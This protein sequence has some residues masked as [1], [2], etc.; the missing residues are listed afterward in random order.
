MLRQAPAKLPASM[1]HPRRL[2]IAKLL[3]IYAITID[4]SRS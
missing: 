2:A 3:D 1:P 4:F